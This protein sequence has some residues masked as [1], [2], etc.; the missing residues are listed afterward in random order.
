MSSGGAP[1]LD[2][3]GTSHL[4]VGIAVT[5]WNGEILDALQAGAM[6]ALAEAGI[7][8]PTLV[9]V[10]GAFELPLAAQAL[11]AHHDVVV[12]LGAVIRG[13]TPHF[14]YVCT[15]ATDGLLRVSL[16]TGKPVGFGVLTCDTEEQAWA[17][18]GVDGS[19]EDKGFDVTAAA[20]LTA[21]ALGG[22]G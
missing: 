14:D 5:L 21:V 18:A 10:P 15:A 17:R 19:T 12:A 1:T 7:S 22:L 9:R 8:D 6:R 20:L 2:L 4:S 11:A 3:S 13:G 16:D